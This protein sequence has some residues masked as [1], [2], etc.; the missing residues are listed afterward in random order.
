MTRPGFEPGPPRWEAG[1]IPGFIKI[2]SAIQKL[3]GAG[4]AQTAW[5]SHIPTLIFFLRISK[6]G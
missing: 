6:L 2:G 4:D 5:R 1:Y 3:M